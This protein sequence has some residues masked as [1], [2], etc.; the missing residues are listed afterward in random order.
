VPSPLE[1]REIDSIFRRFGGE[2]TFKN[3]YVVVDGMLAVIH[4]RAQSL[5][6][7]C[8]G[9]HHRDGFFSGRIIAD[10]SRYAQIL[11]IAGLMLVG[12]GAGRDAAA[13]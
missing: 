10:T 13:R 8:G 1:A 7:L 2:D 6:Q 12:L 4:Q 9:R 3:I 5:I 11:I